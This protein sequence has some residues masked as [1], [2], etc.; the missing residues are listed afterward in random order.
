MCVE[1]R[2]SQFQHHDRP[3]L[4]PRGKLGG[5]WGGIDCRK[6]IARTHIYTCAWVFAENAYA[7]RESTQIRHIH[8]RRVHSLDVFACVVVVSRLTGATRARLRL[9]FNNVCTIAHV[10]LHITY[11]ETGTEI[12][13]AYALAENH[14]RQKEGDRNRNKKTRTHEPTQCHTAD[15]DPRVR[16]LPLHAWHRGSCRAHHQQATKPGTYMYIL[17]IYYIL[18]ERECRVMRTKQ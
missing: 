14:N 8:S 12:S 18:V 2:P 1:Q 10:I 13:G 16:I 15:G 7:K 11:I 5:D 6:H 4:P 3:P 9:R 17:Y